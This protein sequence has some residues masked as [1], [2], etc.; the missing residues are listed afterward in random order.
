MDPSQNSFYAMYPY[1]QGS[2]NGSGYAGSSSGQSNMTYTLG[3]SPET[4]LVKSLS[5]AKDEVEGDGDDDGDGEEVDTA[6]EDEVK[7]SQSTESLGSWEREGLSPKKK[8]RVT[9]A[10]GGACVACR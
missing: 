5:I 7:R 6:K 10:R 1:Q 4:K 3:L 8:P 9:L 2:D